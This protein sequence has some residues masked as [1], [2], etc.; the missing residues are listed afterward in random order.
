MANHIVSQEKGKLIK[1]PNHYRDFTK[2]IREV[3]QEVESII[4]AELAQKTCKSLKKNNP[5]IYRDQLVGLKRV[6]KNYPHKAIVEVL[7]FLQDK[8]YSLRVTLIE[9]FVKAKVGEKELI[10]L[11]NGD[12]ISKFKSLTSPNTSQ[13]KLS[14][15]EQIGGDKI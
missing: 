10:E 11:K 1:N 14:I 9:E 7:T 15:F 13:H 4:P 8:E 3:E 12:E 2:S 5:K 6:H